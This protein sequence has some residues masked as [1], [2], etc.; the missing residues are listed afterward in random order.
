MVSVKKV[1]KRSAALSPRSAMVAGRMKPVVVATA[2]DG[3]NGESSLGIVAAFG[4]LSRGG[5]R[6]RHAAE[7]NRP[8]DAVVISL[9]HYFNALPH[10]AIEVRVATRPPDRPE[11]RLLH[12]QQRF[13]GSD[14][15]PQI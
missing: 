14:R 15:L 5:D 9:R 8:Y 3:G 1:K 4:R 7:G 13:G 6:N 10:E 11:T 2:P 12:A